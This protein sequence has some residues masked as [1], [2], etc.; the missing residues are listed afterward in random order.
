LVLLLSFFSVA[1]QLQFGQGYQRAQLKNSGNNSR[2]TKN[3]RTDSFKVS[4]LLR[5]I[6]QVFH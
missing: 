3:N 5:H 2:Q 6:R 1:H 4:P